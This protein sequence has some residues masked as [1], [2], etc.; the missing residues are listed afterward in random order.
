VKTAKLHSAVFTE[1]T[2]GMMVA[3][4]AVTGVLAI[5][6]AGTAFLR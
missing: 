5:A 2:R 6:L 4:A 1:V 3:A